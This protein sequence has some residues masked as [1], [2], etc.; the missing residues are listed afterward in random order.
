MNREK[1]LFEDM[2]EPLPRWLEWLGV[3]MF[4]FV[5]LTMCL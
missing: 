1:D 2:Y 5:I 4:L 3:I